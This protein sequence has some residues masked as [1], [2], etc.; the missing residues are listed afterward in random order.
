MI[1][2]ALYRGAI[3]PQE[4]YRPM[5]EAHRE[6]RRELMATQRRLIEKMDGEARDEL[7]GLLEELDRVEAM[8]MEEIYVQGMRMGA[9]MMM[10][11]MEKENR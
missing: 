11:L 10:E 9:K 2:E 4:T 7:E 5:T 6:K 3:H 1:L 8:Q